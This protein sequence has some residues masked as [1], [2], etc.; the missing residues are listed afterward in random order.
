MDKML[1]FLG[2]EKPLLIKPEFDHVMIT[3][4]LHYTYKTNAG[5]AANIP[6]TKIEDSRV[7]KT[8]ESIVHTL[9]IGFI[10]GMLDSHMNYKGSHYQLIHILSDL[11]NNKLVV[12]V[13]MDIN[14]VFYENRFN[15]LATMP[16]FD[17]TKTLDNIK[18][19]RCNTLTIT[20]ADVEPESLPDEMKRYLGD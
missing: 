3:E 14:P 6:L 5:V 12:Q 7:I 9:I 4:V 20:I 10:V 2:D 13:E 15:L 19:A 16:V 11:I 1:S 8:P 18:T 17:G